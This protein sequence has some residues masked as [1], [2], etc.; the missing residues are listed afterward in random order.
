MLTEIT[1]RRIIA[2]LKERQYESSLKKL[3][4]QSG[5]RGHKYSLWDHHSNAMSLIS[6]SILMQK[7]NY[8]HLN[9]VR[10]GLAERT[11]DYPWSSARQWMGLESNQD[12]LSADVKEIEWRQH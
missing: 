9:P 3:E 5:P 6:E 12:G 4:R 7:V 1:G 2:Y 10:L 8:T 11:V